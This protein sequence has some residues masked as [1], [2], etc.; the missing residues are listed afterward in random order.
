MH[1]KNYPEPMQTGLLGNVSGHQGA[2]ALGVSTSQHS[3]AV[4]HTVLIPQ[5]CFIVTTDSSTTKRSQLI[6]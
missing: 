1:L 6:L 5:S 4:L 2:P 3:P